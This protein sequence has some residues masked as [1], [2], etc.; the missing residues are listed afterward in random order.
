MDTASLGTVFEED[1]D[2]VDLAILRIRRDNCKD[3]EAVSIDIV[4]EVVPEGSTSSQPLGLSNFELEGLPK[5]RASQISA[6]HRKLDQ[7]VGEGPLASSFRHA[8]GG[9]EGCIQKHFRLKKPSVL[10][11]A[12]PMVLNLEDLICSTPE[13]LEQELERMSLDELL[14]LDCKVSVAAASN[15][16]KKRSSTKVHF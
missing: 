8:G 15:D 4:N 16:R 13:V 9:A 10:Q 3:D 12:A 11:Q 2:S 14:Q 7:F 5:R 1:V 6:R